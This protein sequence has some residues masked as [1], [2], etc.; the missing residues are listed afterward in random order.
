MH[1]KLTHTLVL[2][3]MLSILVGSSGCGSSNAVMGVTP[4]ATATIAPPTVTPTIDV[5]LLAKT[6]GSDFAQNAPFTQV[7]DLVMSNASL[8]FLDY[9]GIKLTDNL[10]PGKPNQIS[11]PEYSLH[12]GP[13]D[14]IANPNLGQSGSHGSAGNGYQ[15]SLCNVGAKSHEL[16]AVGV[17]IDTVEVDTSPNINILEECDGAMS[18]V[19][20][21][22]VGTGCGGGIVGDY[23]LFKATWPGTI[24]AGTVASS[25]TETDDE[26]ACPPGNCAPDPF[27]PFPVA[28]DPGKT[29]KL[30]I[31]M[32]Y[33]IPIGTY[34]FAL[35]VQADN[36]A[37]SIGVTTGPVF[38]YKIATLWSGIV[39]E[40]NSVYQS[41]IPSTGPE[42]FWV[43]PFQQ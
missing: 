1:F 14:I 18:S 17:K 35:S 24:A 5:G 13:S 37:L 39:C 10:T 28:L 9:P 22:N 21:N 42:T 30:Y 33:P 3:A 36:G 32:D 15:I 27:G 40:T 20:R 6:C 8:N 16:Q 12:P 31:N 2:L 4:T 11:G 25:V 23:E 19:K 26:K 29:I 41:Q 34:T 43:C 7:G 38:L